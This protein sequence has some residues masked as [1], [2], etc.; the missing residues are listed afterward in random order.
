LK[1]SRRN[2]IVTVSRLAQTIVMA[3]FIGLLYFD[4]GTDQESIY[5]RRGALFCLAVQQGLSGFLSII[6]AFHLEKLV[7]YREHDSGM[8]TTISY[9]IARLL[10][11]LPI[12]I[13]CPAIFTGIV[14]PL[15]GLQSGVS[16]FFLVLGTITVSTFAAQAL[17]LVIRF[18][19]LFQ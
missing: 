9:F 12:S 2:K 18:V 3:V 4:L 15:I 10:S 5:N 17:G 16:S 6:T 19:P 11:E 7:Y 13:F 1:E 14:Y 8:Y